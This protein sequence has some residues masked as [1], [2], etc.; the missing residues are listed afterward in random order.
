MMCAKANHVIIEL[1]F[2][3][4]NREIRIY[5]IDIIITGGWI[6]YDND[7]VKSI[8]SSRIFSRNMTKTLN[9]VKLASRRLMRI[10]LFYS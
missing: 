4:L 9:S 6:F 7:N 1:L 10:L 8:V 5:L 2:L 3:S